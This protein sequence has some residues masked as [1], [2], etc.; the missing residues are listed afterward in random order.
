L[1][2]VLGCLTLRAQ[3]LEP[4]A[5]SSS[6]LGTNFLVCSYSRS[7]GG[8]VFDPTIPVEDVSANINSFVL[9]YFRTLPVLGRLGNIS[10]ALPYA[11][12]SL[13]GK[14]AGEPASVRR[15]VVRQ[16]LE[17]SCKISKGVGRHQ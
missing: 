4:R 1:W 10:A 16:A 9:G 14:L 2:I 8:V 5:Y 17:P 13:Q 3:D 15:S 7:S 6:P 11:E 12:G